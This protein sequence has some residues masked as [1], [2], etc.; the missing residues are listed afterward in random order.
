MITVI[1]H[2]IPDRETYYRFK[3][4]S[5]VPNKIL[6][7]L[8][9]GRIIFLY[10]MYLIYTYEDTNIGGANFSRGFLESISS[11]LLF[12]KSLTL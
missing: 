12:C 8:C 5:G 10:V 2:E 9:G 4:D 6:N 11:A 3:L 7:K 1:Y